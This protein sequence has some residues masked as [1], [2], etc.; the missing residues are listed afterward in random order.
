MSDTGADNRIRSRHS[1]AAHVAAVLPSA[2]TLGNLACGVLA[3]TCAALGWPDGYV[4]GAALLIV[5]A[6]VLDGVDGYLARLTGR[7]GPFGAQLDSLADVVTFGVAPTIVLVRAVHDHAAPLSVDPRDA[8][9]FGRVLPALLGGLVFTCCA[10][11]RLARYNVKHWHGSTAEASFSGLPSPAAGAALMALTLLA[12]NYVH[13]QPQA[14]RALFGFA[15]P[16]AA[17]AIA[18]LMVSSVP[19]VHLLRSGPLRRNRLL[20][21]FAGA[22]LLLGAVLHPAASLAI[23]SI[24]YIVLGLLTG[25]RR[26]PPD[27]QT[28][29]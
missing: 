5:L 23:V 26:P 2:A 29:T 12:D 11:V 25:A 6:M 10:A 15:V 27:I 7:E 13:A 8:A 24:A 22:V 16:A 20:L 28:S 1:A 4:G 9:T 17:V 18:A 14:A 21:M 19:Y 3:I